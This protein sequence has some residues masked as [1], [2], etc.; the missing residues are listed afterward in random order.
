MKLVDTIIVHSILQGGPG[1]PIFSPGI[2][3][4]LAKGDVEEALKGLTVTDCSLQ[5]KH[6]RNG[7]ESSQIIKVPISSKFLFSYLILHITQ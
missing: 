5:I 7:H 6:D 2:Y 4:Y 1:V 3:Y